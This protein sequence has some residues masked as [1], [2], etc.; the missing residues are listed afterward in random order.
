M[1]MDN[2]KK[3]AFIHKMAHL[4]LQH[5]Q[6]PQHFDGGGTVLGGPTTVGKDNSVK[7]G[8][9]FGFLGD[10]LGTNNNFKASGV[11]LQ[12]GTNAN[13][14]NNAYTGVQGAL[15][16][17]SNLVGNLNPGVNLGTNSQALLTQQLQ[18]QAQGIGPNPA[19]AALN[20]NTGQNIAQQAALAASVR[21]AGS[22]AGLI[23]NQA[24]N[25]GA[26]LQQQAVG[27]QA[28]N[29]AIQQLAAQQQL[30]NLAAQQVGQ[31]TNAIQL[32][33]QA[34]Q[35]EQGLLQ[36]A[37]NAYNNQSLASQ[38]NINNINAG[39]SQ[40]NANSIGNL[41][42]GV[43]SAISSIGGAVS[44][45]FGGS[46]AAGGGGGGSFLPQAP[47]GGNIF[48]VNTSASSFGLAQG[49]KVPAHLEEMARLYHPHMFADGGIA[50]GMDA[51]S[52]TA[53]QMNDQVMTASYKKGGKVPGKPQVDHNASKNDTV[54]A[55]LTPGE[56]VIDLNTLK[57]KGKLGKMARFVAAEIERKKAGRKL[58]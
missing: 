7:P 5:V 49:G 16:Q 23:A 56:V 25:T 48:G 1:A 10:I 9:L 55:V 27:Q 57:D 24:A 13:Q 33:N 14:L 4:G 30:G 19:Q 45:L 29:Q 6:A 18:N 17:T 36:N 47:A 12:Q 40:N 11:D 38:E 22:N 31:G 53:P 37:N 3:L 51:P 43:G 20:Q 21:G 42:K 35:N 50:P 32:Q 34:Q 52:P 41:A 28:Y 39:V 46:P 58:V 26:N 2:E 44:P 8:G 15:G 54:P